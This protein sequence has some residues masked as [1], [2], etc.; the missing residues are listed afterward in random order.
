[1]NAFIIWKQTDHGRVVAGR[2]WGIFVVH[3]AEELSVS[4]P[5]KHIT[6]F[7]DGALLFK[8]SV[9]VSTPTEPKKTKTAVQAVIGRC[10]S[11]IVDLPHQGEELV[12][13]QV[14]KT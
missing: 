7:D 6:K 5:F 11:T 10:E 13:G 14:S 4:K 3:G 2:L 1:M 8:R 9:K 12:D